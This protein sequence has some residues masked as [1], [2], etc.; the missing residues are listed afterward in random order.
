LK[1]SELSSRRRKKSGV[2]EGENPRK[3]RQEVP[4]R[5][6]GY[7]RSKNWIKVGQTTAEF[8]RTK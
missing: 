8:P 5:K 4:A 7:T 2:N 6:V 3:K 1:R